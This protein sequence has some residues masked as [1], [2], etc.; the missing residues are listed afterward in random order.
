MRSVRGPDAINDM[1]KALRSTPCIGICSTTYGDL[2]CRGCNRFAH[3][4]VAWNSYSDDQ[5]LRVWQRL[6]GLRD[7]ATALF[8]AVDDESSLR[9][10]G[11]SVRLPLAD[12]SR[13]TLCY[14]LLRRKARD[15]EKLSEIGLRPLHEDHIEPV[16]VRDAIDSEFRIR[17][18]AYYEHSFRTPV[19]S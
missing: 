1:S 10:A 18:V 19:D 17:S 6:L 16:A 2:V 8:V 15:L 12:M 4:I 9:A 7:A 5:R 13:L 3:E 11:L 14:E